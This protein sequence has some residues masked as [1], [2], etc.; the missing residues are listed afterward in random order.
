MLRECYATSL[1]DCKR[2]RNIR[3]TMA[4]YIEE[5]NLRANAQAS[6]TPGCSLNDLSPCFA[7]KEQLTVA[8]SGELF[9]RIAKIETS[10]VSEGIDLQSPR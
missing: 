6:D 5:R 1:N 7:R 3:D 9:E 4:S 10:V 2:I 8:A